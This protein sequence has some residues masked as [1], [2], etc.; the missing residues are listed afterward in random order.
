GWTVDDGT[1]LGF[2]RPI[3]GDVD[4]E[5]ASI[6]RKHRAEVRKAL[7]NRDS[8]LLTI[9]TG[10][11]AADQAAHF[12]AYST[13]VRNLGTPVFPRRLFT[14]MIDHFG[15]AADILTISSAGQGVASVLSLYWNG[16]VMPYWGGGTQ[17]ARGLRGNELM[18]FGLMDHARGR[19]MRLFDFGR[20]KTGTGP[21]AYK[22]NWG[23]DARPLAYARWSAD[24]APVRDTNPTSAKYRLMVDGWQR[25]PLWLAN[26]AGPFIARQL[27]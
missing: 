8:G 12:A 15:E 10:R 3:A 18:Y 13:S 24:G 6:P 7:A 22:K 19:G 26:F 14:H 1:Y 21:A 25:L 5:L 20:S 16:A 27:G 9:A 2:S 11:S 17:A 23:F 4:A